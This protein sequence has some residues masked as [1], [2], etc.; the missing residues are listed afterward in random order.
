MSRKDFVFQFQPYLSTNSLTASKMKKINLGPP[1]EKMNEGEGDATASS[2]N[3]CNW[4]C[5]LH[6]A[7][8]RQSLAASGASVSESVPCNIYRAPYVLRTRLRATC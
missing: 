3:L 1:R 7:L 2:L 8:S 5:T 6:L 4:A